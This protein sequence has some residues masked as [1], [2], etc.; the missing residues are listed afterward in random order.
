ML[1]IATAAEDLKSQPETLKRRLLNVCVTFGWQYDA[2]ARVIYIPSWWRWNPRENENVLK[3]NL[4]D[5]NDIPSRGLVD[6][7]RVEMESRGSVTA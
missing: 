1:S 2:D 7:K 3:G 5:L 6:G 4:K